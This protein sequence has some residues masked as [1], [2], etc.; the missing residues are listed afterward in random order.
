[1]IISLIKRLLGKRKTKPIANREI[2][3]EAIIERAKHSVSKTNISP[4]AL[5]V[6]NR[7]HQAG[8]QAF[9][10]GGSVRDLLLHKTP[11]DFDVATNAHP[12][13]I[14]DLF[15]NCRLI[16]RRFRLA[17]IHFGRD[18]IEVATF[19]AAPTQD[20]DEHQSEEGRILRDNVYG[21][22]HADVWR[23]DFTINA[24][25]YNIADFSIVDFCGGVADLK[26]KSI[27]LIGDPEQRYREDP[28]RILRAIRFAAKLNFKIE[29]K[30]AAQIPKLADLLEHV[31]S[32]RLFDEIVK[33]YHCGHAFQAHELMRSYGVFHHLFPLTAESLSGPQSKI[34]QH[35]IE[36]TLKNTD[37][38]IQEERPVTPAFLLAALLWRPLQEAALAQQEQGMPPLNALEFAMSHVMST[39]VKRISIP[40]RFTQV[41]REMW[42]LQYRFSKRYGNKAYQLMEHPRFRAAYD[43]LLLRIA[44]GDESPDLGQ[45]WTEFQSASPEHQQTMIAAC[46]QQAAKRRRRRKKK[47]PS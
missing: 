21:D 25:Y 19:R 29:N 24:L 42:L 10:V 44:A 3:P 32:S 37:E 36:S 9:L 2:P 18:I 26:S 46:N 38:R 35:L 1:M 39:Q 20:E 23:R 7:L 34:A 27:R 40:K 4:N 5:K 22:I 13:E 33:L 43:F 17:H 47:N 6:L 15:R 12:Q 30:T 14:K 11:K 28:V 8:Y 31:P 41:M 45:W 16:G